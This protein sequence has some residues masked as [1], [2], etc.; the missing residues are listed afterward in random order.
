MV[1]R[2]AAP[3]RHKKASAYRMRSGKLRQCIPVEILD[4]IQPLPIKSGKKL[5]K[6]FQHPL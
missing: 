2:H 1:N 6:K 4:H 5:S 3:V